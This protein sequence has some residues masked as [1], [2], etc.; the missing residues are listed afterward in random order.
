MNSSLL[1]EGEDVKHSHGSGGRVA[2]PKRAKT[3]HGSDVTVSS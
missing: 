2:E 3:E 1:G